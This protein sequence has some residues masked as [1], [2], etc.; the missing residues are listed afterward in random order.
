MFSKTTREQGSS[1]AW[2][3]AIWPTVAF[4]VGS[5]I[6]VAIMYF[7]IAHDIRQRS[8]AWLTGEAG[9][10]SD[11]A[12]NT[13]RDSVYQRMVEEV[14]ELAS[15]E[16]RGEGDANGLHPSSVFFLQVDP[17]QEPIWVGPP[18]RE[19]FVTA[20]EQ[21]HLIPGTPADLQVPGWSR[22]FRVIYRPHG[23]GGLYLGF[24]DIV[25]ERMLNRL[26]SLCLLV[27]AITVVL[28][29]IITREVA[30]RTLARVD[31]IS[32]AVAEI[33]S[34]DLSTRLPEGPHRDEISR[35][36]RTF[37]RML[38]RIQTSVQELR[39]LTDSVAH[40]LKSPVTS[41]RGGLEVALAETNPARLHDYLAEAIEGLDR[42][43]QVLTTTLDVA[44][45][46][47]GAL[48]IR[49]EPIDLS[50]IVQQ[51]VEL[52]QP[53]MAERHHILTADLQPV[54][55][56]ADPALIHRTIVNLL[57]NEIAHLPPGC[58]IRILLRAV[59]SEAEFV[60]ED[61][62]PGFPADL[63]DRVFDRFVKGENST[64]HGLGLA[65]VQAV[66]HVHGGN[67]TVADRPGGGALITLSLP[68]VSAGV[69]AS[70][71]A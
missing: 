26:I 32:D 45:A 56:E 70:K 22:A 35:L 7:V 43:S 25:A 29:F 11:V 2:R 17:G 9:V 46:D 64:G 41:I 39:A 66:A 62:G 8:D 33:R 38:D 6:A 65:F 44:E 23:H 67:V 3:M 40:D 49:K 50:A 68:V 55:V 1:A 4:A 61:D 30:H 36:S 51:M 42:L 63:R 60:L 19:H 48:Q 31:R 20:V 58:K 28:G 15:R 53:A 12:E 27:W 24:A 37:N 21:A 14:A 10:L 34:D 13:P 47:A 59:N 57:D 16:V 18:R 5:A 69:L 54:V 52:Y 71:S